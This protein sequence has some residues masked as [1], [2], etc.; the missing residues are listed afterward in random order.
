MSAKHILK[1]TNTETV[2]KVYLD[3]LGDVD[4]DLQTDILDS[5]REVLS[6]TQKVN[7]RGIYWTLRDGKEATVSRWNGTNAEGE[8]YLQGAG[9][10]DFA[11]NGFADNI[12]N[13][14]D[15]RV[16]F[17]GA[18]TV[19]LHLSKVEGYAPKFEPATYGSYD[20]PNAAGA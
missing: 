8:T 11:G 19:F 15:I 6:G 16:T 18:G 4:I 3:A 13:T 2:V 14:R 17:T 7:I 10:L 5:D 1:N 12:Y 9:S 20:N